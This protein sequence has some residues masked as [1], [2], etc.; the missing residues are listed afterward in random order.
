MAIHLERWACCVRSSK[1]MQANH[2]CE[3][4]REGLRTPQCL[5]NWD[6]GL[7]RQTPTSASR[8]HNTAPTYI[9]TAATSTTLADELVK[10]KAEAGDGERPTT[11]NA[12]RATILDEPR[13]DRTAPQPNP[14]SPPRHLPPSITS[15]ECVAQSHAVSVGRRRLSQAPSA[16]TFACQCLATVRVLTTP[17]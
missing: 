1:D 8:Q 11:R 17:A 12:P 16:P 6:S 14:P 5:A 15:T 9:K 7:C 2:C 4:A 3:R 13:T 10:H